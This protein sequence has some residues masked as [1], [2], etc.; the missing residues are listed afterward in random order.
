[1]SFSHSEP[2]SPRFPR[3]SSKNCIQVQPIFLWSLCFTL[4]PSAHENLCMLFKNGVFI[5]P[6]P[7]EH[8]HTSP[9]GL[10]CQMLQ[11]L[12]LPVP[13]PH[14]WGFD[15][16]LRTLTPVGESLLYSYFPVCVLPHSGS[17]GLLISCNHPSCLLMWPPLCLLE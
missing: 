6:N 10:Q 9:T 12:F 4:G 17:I 2:Q 13:D 16:R 11:E 15:V 3:R 7:V 1:M 14:A 8:L 5:S